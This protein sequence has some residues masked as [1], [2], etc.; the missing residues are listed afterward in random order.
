MLRNFIFQ[1]ESCFF[2]DSLIFGITG[3]LEKRQTLGPVFFRPLGRQNEL[4]DPFISTPRDPIALKIDIIKAN[5]NK[6]PLAGNN[7]IKGPVLTV[8]RRLDASTHGRPPPRTLFQYRRR[9][10][11]DDSCTTAAIVF[12]QRKI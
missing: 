5:R 11:R 7:L 8:C 12:S 2:F 3:V 4:A 6:L 1:L 10:L 9:L